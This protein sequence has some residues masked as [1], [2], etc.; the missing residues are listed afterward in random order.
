[1]SSLLTICAGALSFG[2]GALWY[3]VFFGKVWLKEVGITEKQ[4]KESGGGAFPMVTSLCFEI[5][6]AFLVVFAI[7]KLQLAV[8]ASGALIAAIAVLS[9][10]KNYLF[11]QRSITLIFINEGYKVVC[12]LIMTTFYYFFR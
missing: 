3:T 12:I 9:S 2:I 11:E 10:L 8:F 6:I 1:M 4:I 7:D 5:L